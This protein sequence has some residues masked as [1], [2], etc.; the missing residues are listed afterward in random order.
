MSIGG[1]VCVEHR[2][3]WMSAMP[4]FSITA[5]PEQRQP[6][7]SILLSQPY[8]IDPTEHRHKLAEHSSTDAGD[9]DERALGE[10]SARGQAQGSRGGLCGIPRTN[11]YCPGHCVRHWEQR[12]K[13]E[14]LPSQ[15]FIPERK[16]DSTPAC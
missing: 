9:V 7:P 11:I 8:L 13:T 6:L 10:Q 12:R 5:S 14:V 16:G 2:G 15:S 3:A 1:G 4:H